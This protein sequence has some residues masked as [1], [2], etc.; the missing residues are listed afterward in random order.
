MARRIGISCFHQGGYGFDRS[1]ESSSQAFNV[2][3]ALCDILDN[4][5]VIDNLSFFIANSLHCLGHPDGAVVFSAKLDLV[6]FDGAFLLHYLDK[7]CAFLRFQ[8]DLRGHIGYLGYK[9]FLGVVSEDSCHGAIGQNES[10]FGCRSI[11]AFLCIFKDVSIL[12]L[13]LLA[14]ANVMGKRQKVAR[15]FDFYEPGGKKHSPDLTALLSHHN[16]YAAGFSGLRHNVDDFL[17][18]FQID[19]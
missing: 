18:V 19:P 9:I 5:L 17:A 13:C 7:F 6:I 3:F 11:N 8:V 1:S 15:L 12:F 10:S 14:F 2:F 16:F 4:P